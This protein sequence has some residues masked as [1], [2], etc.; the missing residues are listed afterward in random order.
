VK[1]ASDNIGLRPNVTFHEFQ[2]PVPKSD[3]I[4]ER[5]LQKLESLP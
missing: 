2:K 3:T 5:Q 4:P 1:A